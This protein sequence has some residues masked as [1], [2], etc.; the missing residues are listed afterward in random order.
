MRT[1]FYIFLAFVVSFSPA[2]AGKYV[3]EFLEAG[4][5]VRAA[6]MG[7]AYVAASNDASALWWNPASI[8][9]DNVPQVYLM[10]SAMYGNMYQLETMAYKDRLLGAYLGASL[11]RMGTDQIPFTRADGFYD[12]GPDGIPGTGD[13][14]EGNGIWDPGEPVDASAVDIRSEN[15]IALLVSASLPISKSIA[16]GASAKILGQQ[17]GNYT[18]VGFG[19]DIGVRVRANP[20]LAFGVSVL[21]VTSTYLRWSTGFSE[22]KLPS[23]RAGTVFCYPLK[24]D[25][26]IKLLFFGD[27]EMRF[28]GAH[29]DAIISI[30]PVTIDPH[31]GAELSLWKHFFPRIGLDRNDFTA[32]AGLKFSRFSVDYAFVMSSIDYVHRVSLS[33]DFNPRLPTK[34]QGE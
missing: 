22:S 1:R 33:I 25:D 32:G 13:A 10:H 18:N 19:M 34:V 26:S 15:D 28:E 9:W 17:I 21:D 20:C 7:N 14:G 27:A 12:Y 24:R 29:D 30:D 4:T 31:I 6:G 11:L 16:W 8:A 5:G 2:F 3:A 23:V